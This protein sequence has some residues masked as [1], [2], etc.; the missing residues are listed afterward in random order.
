MDLFNNQARMWLPCV[1]TSSLAGLNEWKMRH[2][3]LQ[4][5][6]DSGKQRN[7]VGEQRAARSLG[8]NA[9]VL[10]DT[11]PDQTACMPLQE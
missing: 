9:V 5:C 2:A 6:R 1:R 4:G 7:E 11:V 8:P 3:T 10:G